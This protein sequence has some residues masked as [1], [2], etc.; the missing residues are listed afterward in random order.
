[1]DA[2][3]SPASSCNYVLSLR[4]LLGNY[5][6]CF[7]QLNMWL[8]KSLQHLCMKPKL[9]DKTQLWIM[10]RDTYRWVIK[11]LAC[12]EKWSENWPL[13]YQ[14]N[15][16][17]NYKFQNNLLEFR[18][19]YLIHTGWGK[20]RKREM[21]TNFSVFWT[22]WILLKLWLYGG[23][24]LKVHFLVYVFILDIYILDQLQAPSV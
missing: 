24:I 1:M 4:K 20:G 10:D 12:W 11:M 17:L 21:H 13:V 3:Q 6:N 19:M 9:D 2:L 8:C 16:L 23:L 14:P 18:N 22:K 7:N 15:F 5:Y